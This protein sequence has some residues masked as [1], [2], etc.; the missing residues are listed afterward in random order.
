MNK[1]D[2]L[3]HDW[4]S[5]IS[6]GGTIRTPFDS[7]FCAH[8]HYVNRS[9][10]KSMLIKHEIIKD[11]CSICGINT[12]MNKPVTLQVDHIDGDRHNN[13]IDNIRLLC[14]TCHS[15]TKTFS[16]ANVKLQFNKKY[17]SDNDFIDVIKESP[18]ARIALMKLGLQAFGGNYNRIRKIIDTH[19]INF[20]VSKMPSMTELISHLSDKTMVQIGEI[21][22]VSDNA[23]RK[24]L[25][26]YDIPTSKRLIKKYIQDS[27]IIYDVKIRSHVIAPKGESRSDS[28][29][30][31]EGVIQIR[32]LYS[33]GK[34]QRII[35]DLMNVSKST[36]ANV[37]YGR[38]WVH[39]K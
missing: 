33:I 14:P 25:K 18:N 4:N 20:N 34:S 5:P 24:W 26:K 30:T 28:K 17:K 12:W 7:V 36:I 13:L 11:V 6:N 19:G 9:L 10:I 16:G 23:I 3:K 31:E 15:Q 32:Y 39:V 38:S 35:A 1:L 21:Y 22:G 29:L 8:S 2:N 27:G 37:I